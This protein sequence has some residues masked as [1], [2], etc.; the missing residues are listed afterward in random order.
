MGMN[1][2]VIIRD[3]R[4]GGL[5]TAAWITQDCPYKS[6]VRVML[7][8]C[9]PVDVAR[10]DVTEAPECL[11]YIIVRHPVRAAGPEVA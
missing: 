3:W 11:A 2:R 10:H 5:P 6:T 1:D 4:K 7:P 9:G 8:D